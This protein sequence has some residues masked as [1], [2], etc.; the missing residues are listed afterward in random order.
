MNNTVRAVMD[1]L[2][3]NRIDAYFV[4][5]REQLLLLLRRLI[6]EGETVAVGGSVTLEETGVLE[7]LR[8]G[9]YN[10]L[11]RYAKGLDRAAIEEI[12]RRS[13]YADTYLTSANAVTMNGELFNVDGNGNRVNAITFGPTSVIV[14]CGT[15]KIVPDLEAAV[16]RV[17]TIAAPLNAKRLSKATP[18][19]ASGH[20][21]K[22]DGC[23]TDGCNSVDR[24][25]SAYVVTGRQIK[26]GR[27][28]VVL[29]DGDFGY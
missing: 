27:I 12:F 4:E 26:K 13:F 5:N 7:H 14:I 29:I 3:D 25:C 20:C 18:C 8:S 23:M 24:I 11:D 17:K 1:R 10:F 2:N 6:Q 22:V 16:K 28:K 15:N 9:R 19:A 21:L